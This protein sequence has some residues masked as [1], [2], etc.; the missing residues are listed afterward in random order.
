MSKKRIEMNKVYSLLFVLCSLLFVLFWSC[1]H[2][3]LG[4]A[5]QTDCYIPGETIFEE[6]LS[7]L[8]GVWYSHYAG[9]GRLDGYRIRKWSEL[10]AADKAKIQSLFPALNIAAPKTYSTQDTPGN[11]DYILFYDDTVYGQ[12]D[13][14]TA[15]TDGNW[16]FAY[17]GVLRAINIFNGD[18]NRGAIIIEYFETADPN[19]LWDPNGYA[20]QGLAPGEKPFFGIYYRVLDLDVVQ[21]A[22]A[23]DLAALYAGKLYHTEKRTLQEAIDFNSVE[24]EAE[25][26][27]WGVVIPQNREKK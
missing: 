13:D 15:A 27:S 4:G 3:Q 1:D 10:T 5:D 21:M 23:V 19:W 12:Q 14:D 18:K 22:N 17:A 6:R 26:I 25:L 7:S 8:S 11:D 2:E 16:G 9:I 24:N 20:W